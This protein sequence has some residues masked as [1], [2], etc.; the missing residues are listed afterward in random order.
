MTVIPARIRHLLS[1]PLLADARWPLVLPAV[2]CDLRPRFLDKG[3]VG[4]GHRAVARNSRVLLAADR[5]LAEL[6]GRAVQV[7]LQTWHR[8]F[9]PA[10]PPEPHGVLLCLRQLGAPGTPPLYT[11]CLVPGGTEPAGLCL[12]VGG[13]L[14]LAFCLPDAPKHDQPAVFGTAG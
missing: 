13:G 9:L 6:P 2:L 1:G 4:Q 8:T 3:R 10:D 14:C 12:E 5:P 7:R 11:T